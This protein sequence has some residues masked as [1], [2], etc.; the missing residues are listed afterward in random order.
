MSKNIDEIALKIIPDGEYWL[1][2]STDLVDVCRDLLKQALTEKKLC[3]PMSE[4]EIL[5]H[6][7]R[8]QE[9]HDEMNENS[10]LRAKCA[11]ELYEAQFKEIK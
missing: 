4:E 3:V 7:E 10:K 1:D 8:Y 6:F 9:Q 5:K 2:Q 11:K